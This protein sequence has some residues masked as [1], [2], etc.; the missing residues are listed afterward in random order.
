MNKLPFDP[1][2]EQAEESAEGVLDGTVLVHVAPGT[3]PRVQKLYEE[4]VGLQTEAILLTITDLEDVRKATDLLSI[5]SGLKKAL[6]AARTEYTRPLNSHLSAV[7]LEFKQ[8]VVPLEEADRT[9]KDKVRVY[10]AAQERIRLEQERINR[11]R[12]DAARAEMELT[13]ELSEPV[14]LVEI[15]PEQPK[16]VHAQFGTLGG[17]KVWKFEIEDFAL[18]PDFYKVADTTAIRH[19]VVKKKTE[20]P[21]PGVR[22]WLEDSLRVSIRK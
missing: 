1:I 3:D 21:I 15:I 9:A 10:N 20:N 7:N 18:L 12:E 6:E 13:G 17:A 19:E 4:S 2:D 11:L 5:I 22:A 8:F 16:Q 14:G